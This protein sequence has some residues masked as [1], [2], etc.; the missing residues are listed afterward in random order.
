MPPCPQVRS[1]VKRNPNYFNES[2]SAIT[3]ADS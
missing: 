3:G 2:A 1:S